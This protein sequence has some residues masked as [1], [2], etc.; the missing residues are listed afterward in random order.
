MVGVLEQSAA[1][2]ILYTKSK[3][4]LTVNVLGLLKSEPSLQTSQKIIVFQS[5]YQDLTLQ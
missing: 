2:Y 4:G 5:L 1:A 3:Y